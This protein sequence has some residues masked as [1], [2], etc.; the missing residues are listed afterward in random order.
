MRLTAELLVDMLRDLR[1]DSP[2]T[3]ARSGQSRRR[4]PRIGVRLQMTIL[5]LDGDREMQ[6]VTVRVRDIGRGGFGFTHNTPLQP[7]QQFLVELPRQIGGT[8]WILGEVNRCEEQA[9]GTCLIGS[10]IRLDVPTV[11]VNRL[12]QSATARRKSA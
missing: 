1:A 8:T 5:P 6:Q 9:G 12:M 4:L 7:G 10:R 11:E 3:R 2:G